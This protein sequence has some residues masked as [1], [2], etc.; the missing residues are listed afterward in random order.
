MVALMDTGSTHNLL[1]YDVFVTLQDK[2]FTPVNMDMKVA[3]STLSNNIVGKAQLN[4]VF[5]TTTGTVVLPLTYL[6]AHKLNGY[7]SIIGA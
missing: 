5:E 4:T 3:G 6:V 1:A 2:T 7:H